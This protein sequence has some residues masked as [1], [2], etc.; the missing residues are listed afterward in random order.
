M[1]FIFVCVCGCVWF[2]DY[3]LGVSFGIE[4][5]FLLKVV[6]IDFECFSV[7]SLFRSL[8]GIFFGWFEVFVILEVE[9]GRVL[10]FFYISFRVLDWEGF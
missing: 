10:V 4:G 6:G 3:F 7:Y 5:M 2:F 9:S 1:V 8:E